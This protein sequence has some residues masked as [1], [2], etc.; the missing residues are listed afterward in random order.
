MRII[1]P[2]YGPFDLPAFL[3]DLISQ[4]E[5]QRLRA[6]RLL[7]SPS[8]TLPAAGEIK[9]FSHTLGVLRL[10]LLADRLT[11][12]AEE[13]KCL[14]AAVLLHDAG[15]PAFGHMFEYQLQHIT[16]GIWNHERIVDQILL[17]THAPENSSHQI[18][19]H[20]SINFSNALKKCGVR[21]DLL[22]NIVSGHHPLSPALFGGLDL[23]NL[24]NVSRMAWGLGL[25]R[26]TKLNIEL[27]PLFGRGSGGLLGLNQGKVLNLLEDW[28]QLRRKVYSVLNFDPGALASQAILTRVMQT[29]LEAGDLTV[30]DWFL[31]DEAMLDR[32]MENSRTK[33]MISSEFFGTLPKPVFIIQ[34]APGKKAL[35]ERFELTR[36]IETV[37]T[38]SSASR[39]SEYLAHVIVDNGT[40]EK[41]LR[42]NDLSTGH[43][44][45]FGTKSEST[46]LCL[47][48]RGD[49]PS[50]TKASA[51]CSRAMSS[52]GIS[53]EQILYQQIGEDIEHTSSEP[54]LQA[55]SQYRLGF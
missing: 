37:A 29:M 9:R 41:R 45:S 1:D 19:A 35:P 12:N 4:P 53:S 22:R 50:N 32:C 7:N 54:A 55:T 31:T 34:V 28:S 8:P 43:E 17:G 18:F 23:D 51:L 14:A 16:G 10:C 20:R 40:F 36:Q 25:E 33:R 5:I 24:D 48:N 21:L 47:F 11:D 30:S 39:N 15:T 27:A 3:E 42:F 46:I 49:K 2:L 38:T 13:K 6:I 44:W 26:N 52:L